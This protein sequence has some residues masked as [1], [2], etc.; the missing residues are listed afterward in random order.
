MSPTFCCFSHSCNPHFGQ[1]SCAK[2]LSNSWDA[3][4]AFSADS[5]AMGQAPELFTPIPQ[6]DR[7]PP[8]PH[9]QSK[10]TRGQHK[11]QRQLC[12]DLCPHSE[13]HEAL[14]L[15]LWSTCTP[16]SNA[17][18]GDTVSALPMRDSPATCPLYL[19]SHFALSSA[20]LNLASWWYHSS[21][22]CS[23]LCFSP[24]QNC[25][26]HWGTVNVVWLFIMINNWKVQSSVSKYFSRQSCFSGKCQINT[27]VCINSA[28]LLN[29]L[30][31]YYCLKSILDSADCSFPMA[32]EC[33]TCDLWS[34]MAT[35]VSQSSVPQLM[36]T[37]VVVAHVCWNS[38]CGLGVGSQPLFWVSQWDVVQ[39]E[40]LHCLTR[41]R[42]LEVTLC[43]QSILQ[44]HCA[45]QTEC[46]SLSWGGGHS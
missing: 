3:Q 20:F 5:W 2:C 29:F 16:F 10:A 46:L 34:G 42:C 4:R 37:Y 44:R 24:R 35:T 1:D 41:H 23:N 43:A 38:Q 13:L 11:G 45:A 36:Q 19:I 7:A 33:D 14:P 18:Q 9:T 25:S 30:T 31:L 6:K 8:P 22:A 26:F 40:A 21:D 27:C 12:Y 15:L 17:R 39:Q 32:G 28:G